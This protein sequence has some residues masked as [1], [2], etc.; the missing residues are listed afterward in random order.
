MQNCKKEKEKKIILFLVLE[1][2]IFYTL[3]ESL[4]MYLHLITFYGAL[5]V[6]EAPALGTLIGTCTHL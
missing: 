1:I 2:G 3:I 4:P 6:S 5:P